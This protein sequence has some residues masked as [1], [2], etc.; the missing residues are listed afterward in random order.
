MAEKRKSYDLKFKELVIKYAQENNNKE[1]GR[2][3][4]I[5][6]SMIRRWRKKS[7]DISDQSSSSSQS[8]MRRLSGA[9]RN[10]FLGTLKRNYWI[11]LSMSV[12]SITM[13]HVN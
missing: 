1:A 3:F 6:E 10:Q 7:S 13:S 11:K 9:G 2:K 5:G 12:R 4:S 8:K